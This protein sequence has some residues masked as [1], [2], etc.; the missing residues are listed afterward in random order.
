MRRKP[1]FAVVLLL[2]LAALVPAASA[3]DVQT[4]SH[5]IER[6]RAEIAD[7]QRYVYSG[8]GEPVSVMPSTT[9]DVGS[10]DTQV[11]LQQIE[12]NLRI[13]TGQVEE[14]QYNQRQLSSRLDA[15]LADVDAR[16]AAA[17]AVSTAPAATDTT[18]AT[19]TTTDTGAGTLT[20]DDLA[21]GESDDAV[22]T[23]PA[24]SGGLPAG[25]EI[26][27]YNYAFSLLR[28]AD[29][30][31][32]E[33]AFNE[34]IALHPQSDLS[35][36]AYYWLGETY[37]VRG[38][39]KDAAVSFLKGYQQFPNGDKAPD[40]LLKLG[41]T[42]VRLDKGAEACATFN[43]LKSKFPDAAQTVRDKAAQ[44]AAAAGCG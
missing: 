19:G 7:L 31:G 13:L 29:Y 23:A 34:F 41:M 28:K 6:L 9:P 1:L 14:L 42:L 10:P 33:V 24:A 35:G 11:R 44:E 21:A 5:E 30:D 12:E 22:V 17:A 39:Y 40:N 3:Q 15:V 20:G 18:T 8:Q 32:A 26:D 16:L 27:Q 37:Y 38:S 25:S 4:L 36:N 43:E 2:G